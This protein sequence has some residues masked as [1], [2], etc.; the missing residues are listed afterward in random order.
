MKNNTEDVGARAT[1]IARKE[2]EEACKLNGGDLAKYVE[3]FDR[4]YEQ[5]L[6]EFN[7]GK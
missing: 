6:R 2:A 4:V 5:V 3:V 1:A 7:S